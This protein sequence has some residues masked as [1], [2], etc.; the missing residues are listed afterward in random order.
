MTIEENKNKF[1]FSTKKKV[2]KK[3]ND[4]EKWKILVVD[5]EEDVHRITKLILR[6]FSYQNKELALTHAYSGEEAMAILRRESDFA[7]VLLDI[8]MESEHSG[9]DVVQYIR[10]EL[11]NSQIRIILRTGQPGKAPLKNIIVQYEINDYKQK[12]ELTTDKMF[13]TI[14]SALR[15]YADIMS[16]HKNKS[17][18]ENIIAASKNLFQNNSL[19]DFAQGILVHL[20]S[21]LNLDDITLPPSMVVR[22]NHGD[23]TIIGGTGVNKYKIGQHMQQ[24]ATPEE[25]DHIRKAAAE[26]QSQFTDDA[27][28]GYFKTDIGIE[29]II[30]LKSPR[31]LGSY[32]RDLIGIFTRNVG[33]AFDN[34]HL[35]NDIKETQNELIHT[36]GQAIE[37]RAEDTVQHVLRVGEY[38]QLMARKLGLSDREIITIRLAAPL[39][40]IGKIGM[41]D[42]VLKKPDKLTDNELKMMER[43]TIL[44]HQILSKSDRQMFKMAATI[45]LEHHERWDGTGYPNKLAGEKISIYGRITALADVFDVLAHDRVYDSK[46]DLD[47][48]KDYLTKQR[49]RQFDPQLID[50]FLKHF[51][52]FD[53]L[54]KKY[55]NP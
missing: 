36:L 17:N 3:V 16:I 10:K 14:I 39:H 31:P 1:V 2:E 27:Y 26:K 12:T 25:A 15:S 9:L 44:G 54:R 7:L 28:Y 52:E 33:V 6:E 18:L 46:W 49:G 45:A 24:V 8:V 30:Q 50:I 13:A 23:L 40:D 43:H 55:P 35:I 34:I 42:T 20:S 51:I 19:S 32:E 38:A 5:D 48:V 29:Y 11:Q 22:A 41:D 47:K 4:S 37:S 21:I 53:A